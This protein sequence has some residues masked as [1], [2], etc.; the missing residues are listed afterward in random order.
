MKFI[1]VARIG[2]R[3]TAMSKWLGRGVAVGLMCLLG[4]GFQFGQSAQGGGSGSGNAGQGDSKK[5]NL[6]EILMVD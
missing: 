3:V 5:L 4:T 2:R 6:F 1:R